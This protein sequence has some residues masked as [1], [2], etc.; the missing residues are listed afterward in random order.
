MNR[1]PAVLLPAMTDDRLQSRV[2]RLTLFAMRTPDRMRS[3]I[4]LNL[5][6]AARNELAFRHPEIER[7]DRV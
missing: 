5:A 4:A 6:Y 2:L 1:E 3:D 7:D